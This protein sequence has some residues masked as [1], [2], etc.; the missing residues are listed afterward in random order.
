MYLCN[1]LKLCRCTEQ[2]GRE[3]VLTKD[4]E[5]EMTVKSGQYIATN[6]LKELNWWRYVL[7]QTDIEYKVEG[8][9][10]VFLS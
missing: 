9:R 3:C 6:N 7:R 2:C 10:I 1:R 8:F 4:K 5:H